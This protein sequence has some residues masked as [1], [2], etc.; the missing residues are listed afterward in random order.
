MG[1]Q[2][3]HGGLL[4]VAIGLMFGAFVV[5]LRLGRSLWCGAQ[6]V[7]GWRLGRGVAREASWVDAWGVLG[8]RCGDGA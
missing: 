6:G 2:L 8:C 5:E 4:G 7:A 1:L 3:G